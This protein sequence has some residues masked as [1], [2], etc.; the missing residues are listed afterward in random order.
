MK[1][2]F[3]EQTKEEKQ[4]YDRAFGPLRNIMEI[5]LLF[6]PTAEKVKPGVWHFYA[7]IAYSMFP[8]MSEEFSEA[9]YPANELY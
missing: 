4:W 7:K 5:K 1:D 3:K 8:E 2:R 9:N 6:R